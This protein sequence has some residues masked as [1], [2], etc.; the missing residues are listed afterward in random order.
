MA[1]TSPSDHGNP[2]GIAVLTQK[3][4]TSKEIEINKNSDKWLSL[5]RRIKELL[6]N[7]SQIS[8]YLCLTPLEI[9]ERYPFFEIAA[10]EGK[11]L[12]ST[13]KF[14]GCCWD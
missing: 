6:N 8:N 9:C 12:C 4:T 14:P 7:T 5:D 3:V 2:S 1:F 10:L 13:G 11:L